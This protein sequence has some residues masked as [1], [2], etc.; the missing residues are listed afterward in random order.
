MKIKTFF[1]FFTVI[2]CF[3]A[4]SGFSQ[5]VSYDVHACIDVIDDLHVQGNHMWWVHHGGSNPGQHSDCSGDVLSVN[6]SSWGNWSTPYTLSG[7]TTCMTMTSSVTQCSNVCNLIQAPS[8]SNGWETIYAFDDSGPSGAHNYKINFTFC[9]TSTVPILTFT[10]SSPACAGNSITFTYTGNASNTAVYNWDFGDGS[11]VSHVQSPSHTYANPGTFNVSLDITSEC[12][13]HAGPTV[14]PLT[15]S[16]PP[17][18]SFT[19]T[20]PAC[21]GAN[22]LITYTGN[23]AAGDTYT[24]TFGGGTIASGTGQG[25]YS[26][27]WAS[28]GTKIVTLLVDENGCSSPLKTDSVIV[29]PVP[30]AT[31]TPP[32]GQCKRGNTFSFTAAG[33]FIPSSTFIW[34]FGANASPS[35][36]A[37]QNPSGIVFVNP[38]YQTVT[39]T[40]VKNG[41]LSNTYIDSVQ[42]YSMP[43]SNFS[44]ADVCSKQPMN[45]N[46][47]SSVPVGTI[48]G[49]SWSFSDSS[50]LGSAQNIIHTYNS[51]GTYPVS[52]IVTSNNGCKDTVAKNAVVHPLPQAHI[53]AANVCDGTSVQFSD[54][55]NI[56]PTD[57]IHSWRWNFGDS[58]PFSTN[59]TSSHLY[60]GIGQHNVQLLV[61]SSFGCP[62]SVSKT[63]IVNPNP[64]VNFAAN[65]TAGCEALC[66]FFQDQSTIPS[67]GINTNW[68]W[69][70]GDGSPAGNSQSFDHCYNN[71]SVDASNIFNVTLTVTSDSGCASTKTKI[72][73][74]TVYP[75]PKAIFE[76]LPGT[77]SIVNPV[78]SFT[79][80]S[81]GADFWSWNF[82][83]LHTET[84]SNPAPHTYADT[85]T[86]VITL[87]TPNQFGCSDTAHQTIVIEADFIFYIPNAFSPDGDGKNETFSGKGVFISQ[88]EMMIFDRWGNLIYKTEDIDKPWDGKIN[89]S[90]ATAERDVYIYVINVTD[91]KK[92]K[93]SYKGIVTLLR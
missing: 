42:V 15:I 43:V 62:D 87:I 76:V 33:N 40:F 2:F 78:I 31:F 41:C 52:L 81:K 83:D 47:L 7:V 30:I 3:P 5:C 23:G 8:G 63:V 4:L 9:P 57:T 24:W 18:A 67:G 60:S 46:D 27:N 51:P 1:F 58:S 89:Q 49:W 66:I 84:V 61:F 65:D 25:P 64:I 92:K 71:D 16:I 17:T 11:P 69:N 59:Q 20:S 36:S 39:M 48:S 74:I 10:I 90:S 38:G 34:T 79:D 44:F 35:S 37:L 88:Y 68:L 73:Y 28:A 56:L 14:T 29:S 93:H 26:V 54:L 82:G 55:S 80:L 70:V 21:V 86:Y 6:G 13:V 85:G 32:G 77:A 72:N 50:P 22:A 12:N 91:F 75:N 45:F 19:S 53:A